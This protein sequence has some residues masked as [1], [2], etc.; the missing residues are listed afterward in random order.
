[1]NVCMI[2]HGMMGVWHSEALAKVDCE[3]HTL[4]GRRPEPTAEFARRYGYRNWTVDLDEAL[5]DPEVD[6]V[7][8]AGPSETHAEMACAALTAGKP[9]LVEIP[10]AMTLADAERVVETA[11]ARGLTLGV[12]HPMRF[13][14]ER[15]PL[16]E[17]IR[18]GAE[19]VR[20][21]HGRFFIWRLKNV[22]ATGYRRSWT[23]NLLWH[24]TTHLLDLGLWAVAGGEMGQVDGQIRDVYGT[25]PAPDPDTGIPMENVLVVETQADQT[26]VATGSYY[27]RERIYD[28]LI[29]TDRDSYRLDELTATLTTGDGV[30][31]LASEQENAWLTAQ[32]FIVAVRDGREPLVPGWSVLP[33]MRVLERAQALWDA[34]HS[35]QSLPGRP[36]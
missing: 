1:M 28:T 20:H 2:G 11:Q 23:D 32:D 31:Q 12:V 16:I 27:A 5:A 21:V 25:M 4:V 33:T 36:L 10:I 13:R 7:I 26:V 35:R 24:H 29:V 22:G 30:Q 14:P 17:R 6:V 9:T 18:A 15:A 34:K 8:V 3:L 19:R